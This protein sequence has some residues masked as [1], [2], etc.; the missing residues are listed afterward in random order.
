MMKLFSTWSRRMRVVLIAAATVAA[1]GFGGAQAIAG[2]KFGKDQK[3]VC[4]QCFQECDAIGM[5]YGRRVN[6]VC[7]CCW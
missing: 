3:G 7:K 4:T 1:L 6:G 5:N 2:A